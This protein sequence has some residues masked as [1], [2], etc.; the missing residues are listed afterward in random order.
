MRDGFKGVKNVRALKGG[1]AIT[2]FFVKDLSFMRAV[3]YIQ[4]SMSAV[5]RCWF[6]ASS[7]EE[8]NKSSNGGEKVAISNL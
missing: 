5:N 1:N 2:S 6:T 7:V 3:L 4:L 8:G